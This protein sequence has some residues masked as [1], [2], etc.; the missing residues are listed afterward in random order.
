MKRRA[1]TLSDLDE[2]AAER[3]S[4]APSPRAARP[5]VPATGMRTDFGFELPRGYVDPDGNV[6]RRGTMRL[7]TARDELKPQIDLRVKENPAYLSVVLLSQVIT[8]LGTVTDV[9]TG[10]VESMY[11]TD[12]AFLQDF[13][14]RI[15]SEGHTRAEVTCP[16]CSVAF[17][18]DLA[19]SRLGE[20]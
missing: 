16:S 4:V 7:A 15:N 18:V 19:G 9:H 20:S 13:Y 6:H 14:R 12:I 3:H 8:S 1:L 10:L 17:E 11:A 5:G 2:L